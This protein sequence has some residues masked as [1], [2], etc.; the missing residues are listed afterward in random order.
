M[1]DITARLQGR[2][3]AGQHPFAQAVEQHER[4]NGMAN[5]PLVLV[6]EDHAATQNVLASVLELQGYRVACVVN[7]Q[8]ALEW[9]ED[10]RATGQL[11]GIILLDLFMP[12]MNGAD[13]LLTLRANWSGVEAL[14]PV[15]LFT[16]D[17]GNHEDLGCTDILPKPFHVRDLLSRLRRLLNNEQM[18]A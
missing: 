16:V 12:V 4:E 5:S 9:L 8:E 2:E 17:Q 11:P 10:A 6:V 7:G 3:Q 1:I 15:L 13:F 14:P 18:S